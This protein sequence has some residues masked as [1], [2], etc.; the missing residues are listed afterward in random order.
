MNEFEEFLSAEISNSIIY[1]K[2]NFKTPEQ[3]KLAVSELAI[4]L[5]VVFENMVGAIDTVKNEYNPLHIILIQQTCNFKKNME[6]YL[7]MVNRLINFAATNQG[8]S[9]CPPIMSKVKSDYCPDKVHHSRNGVAR[10]FAIHHKVNNNLRKLLV[11]EQLTSDTLSGVLTTLVERKSPPPKS[12][13]FG[14]RI[15]RIENFYYENYF[16]SPARKYVCIRT[17]DTPKPYKFSGREFAWLSITITDSMYR[18]A[19]AQQQISRRFNRHGS[20]VA[21]S[22]G[23]SYAHWR[24]NL[25]SYT[26]LKQCQNKAAIFYI[27]LGTNDASFLEKRM[28]SLFKKLNPRKKGGG[29]RP[30]K[31]RN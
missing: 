20:A 24:Q 1:L 9:L 2:R 16:L 10:L 19:V 27:S 26:P 23:S 15:P 5:R 14:P 11:D 17:K 29:R 28:K 7:P 12:K 6:F 25:K 8:A 21:I 4:S 22:P 13:N 3:V 18:G 31:K 30:T